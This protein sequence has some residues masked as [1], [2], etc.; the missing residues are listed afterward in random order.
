MPGLCVCCNQKPGGKADRQ[1]RRDIKV[2]YF[3]GDVVA[4]GVG[5][6]VLFGL[7]TRVT[8]TTFSGQYDLIAPY[9]STGDNDEGI[10][11]WFAGDDDMAESG[12]FI[13]GTVESGVLGDLIAREI[14]TLDSLQDE[15]CTP[16]ILIA[17]D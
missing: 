14:D 13:R 6:Y 12:I 17:A 7:P 9:G 4:T 11:L 5:Q 3:D 2:K 15:D 16:H 10:E 1:E 8:A